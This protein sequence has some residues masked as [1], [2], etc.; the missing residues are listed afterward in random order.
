MTLGALISRLQHAND[1]ALT[2]GALGDLVL[3]AEV[4][5]GAARHGETPGEYLAASAGQFASFAANADWMRLVGA[6]ERAS[7]P[8]QAAMRC[9]LEWA[10][11]RDLASDTLADGCACTAPNAD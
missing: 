7:D 5:A 11:A 1:A 3:Y 4:T 6:V 10:I 2:I 8:G 9:I